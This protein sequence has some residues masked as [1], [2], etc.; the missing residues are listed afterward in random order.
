MSL[1][2]FDTLRLNHPADRERIS[3]LEVAMERLV[4]THRKGVIDDQ[5]LAQMAHINERDIED[6]LAEL[7]K[8]NALAELWLWVCPITNGT[9]LEGP[10]VA[11]FPDSVECDK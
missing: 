11:A 2:G 9:V 8:W 5:V 7:V 3:A 1:A 6:F 4:R 10:S